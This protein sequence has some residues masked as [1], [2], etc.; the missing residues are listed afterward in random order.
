MFILRLR[1]YSVAPYHYGRPPTASQG[2]KRLKL[3]GLKR[4]HF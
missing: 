4:I 1:V 2:V 3:S